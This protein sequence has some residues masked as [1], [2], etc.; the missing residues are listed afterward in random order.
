MLPGPDN[1]LG[2]RDDI[3]QPLAQFTR[4]VLIDDAGPN[5]RRIRITVRYNVAGGRREYTLETLIS[6]FA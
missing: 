1:Q 3:A 4:E 2:S 5:L 6:A